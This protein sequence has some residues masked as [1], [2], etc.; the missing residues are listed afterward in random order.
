MCALQQGNRSLDLVG[1][2]FLCLEVNLY[3]IEVH[4]RF[5][6]G[7]IVKA[8]AVIQCEHRRTIGDVLPDGERIG[9]EVVDALDRHVGTADP[10]RIPRL[11]GCTAVDIHIAKGG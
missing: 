4:G 1:R 9:L 7:R 2:L 6:V 8:V 10:E 3:V 5:R 11:L